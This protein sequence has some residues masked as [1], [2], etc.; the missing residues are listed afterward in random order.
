MSGR[1]VYA[2]AFVGESFVMVRHAERAWEMPGG[3]VEADE[4]GLD[5]AVREFAEETGMELRPVSSFGVPGGEVFVGLAVGEG[6]PEDGSEIAEVSLFGELPESLSFPGVEYAEV[7]EKA[8][9][10]VESFKRRKDIIAPAT[11]LDK[12]FHRSM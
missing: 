7:L 10:L 12:P 3:R 1:F 8:R 9:S 11:P 6:V 2:V 5:A 4:T